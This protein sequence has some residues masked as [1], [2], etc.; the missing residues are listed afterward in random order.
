MLN[1]TLN[2]RNFADFRAGLLQG[3]AVACGGALLRVVYAYLEARL[4]WKW[5]GKLT[6]LLHE[7]YFAGMNYYMMGPGAKA[8][9]PDQM[10]DP[11]TRISADVNESVAGFAKCFSDTLYTATAG[12]L[13]TVRVF[14][15]ARAPLCS[16]CM[17]GCTDSGGLRERLMLLSS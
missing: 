13:Y 7:K 12:V 8:D 9:S 16:Y 17:E 10:S 1:G 15:S 2:S 6:R 5:R 11:D 3:T 4:T 14:A